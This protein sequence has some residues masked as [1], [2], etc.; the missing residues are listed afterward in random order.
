MA[1][2]EP[3]RSEAAQA[4]AQ[5]GDGDAALVYLAMCAG[6]Q[7]QLP[8]ER[9]ESAMLTLRR[10]GL[11]EQTVRQ[12]HRPEYTER[13]VTDGLGTKE[14]GALV[15]QVQRMLGRLLSTEELKCLLSIHDYLRM[16]A[17]VTAVLV[18][19]CIRRAKLRGGRLPTMRAIEKEA[20][21]WADLGIDTADAAVAHMREQLQKQSRV[22]KICAIIQISGR[23]LTA[24]ELRYVESWIEWGFPDDAIRLAYEKT[25]LNTTGMKWA[26]MNGI[27]KRWHEK[28]LHTIAEIEQGDTAKP[29]T[30]AKK[31]GLSAL[32]QEVIAQLMEED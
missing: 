23:S 22:G 21:A 10:L 28:G 31:N 3:F 5:S 30:Q 29:H 27:L 25:C 32:E 6:T 18:S 17:E 11:V 26:Y 20:Y 9:L 16:P 14:F 12:T 2:Q 19:Y 15:G 8:P 13:D 7:A 1:K 24:P 4:L